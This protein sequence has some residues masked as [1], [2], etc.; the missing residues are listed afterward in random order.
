M[1]NPAWKNRTNS[2]YSLPSMFIE[3]QEVNLQPERVVNIGNVTITEARLQEV[4]V[5]GYCLFNAFSL[6]FHGRQALQ[7]KV[8][9][10]LSQFLEDEAVFLSTFCT[11]R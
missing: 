4:I 3:H 1:R 7:N 8:Q 2:F 9:E 11:R 10:K 6:T 5:D